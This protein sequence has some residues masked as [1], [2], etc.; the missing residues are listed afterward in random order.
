MRNYVIPLIIIVA[1]LVGIVA[2]AFLVGAIQF[3]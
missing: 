2:F 1:W 3:G